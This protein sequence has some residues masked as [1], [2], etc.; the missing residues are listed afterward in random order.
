V[1]P[2]G[3]ASVT[4]F[5]D[6]TANRT[7]QSGQIQWKGSL[8]YDPLTNIILH[9]PTW[10]AEEG[11][12]P[13]LYDDGPIADGGHE[14]PGATADDYI[15]SVEVYVK[16]DDA[17]ETKF[18]YGVINEWGNWIWEGENGEFVLPA[19]STDLI[20]AEGYYI[21][22]F[23]TYDLIVTLDI[24]ELNPDFLPF[25]PAADKVYLKGSMNSWDPRQLLDNG[26]KGDQAAADGVYTYHHAENLGDHDG[27]LFAGQHV[28]FVF[29]LNQLEYKRIDALSDGVSARTNCAGPDIWEDVPIF[30]EPESRGRIKNTTVAICEGGGSVSV[31]SIVPSSGDP[32]GGTPVA[33]YGSAFADGAQVTFGG[34][35]AGDVVFVDPG[36]INCT[37]PAHDPGSVAVRVTNPGG[38]FGEL[39]DG[40]TYVQGDQ[41]EILFLQPG[42]GSTGGGTLVT[43]TGRRFM[44]G[45]QVTFGSD[46]AVEVSVNNAQEITCRTPAHTAGQ[47][48]VTV[49]NPGGLS[50]TFPEGFE[51][52]VSTGPHIQRVEPAVGSTAGGEDVTLI[53]SGFAAGA[54]AYFDDVLAQD[55]VVSPPGAIA[56]KTPPHAV[57]PV[58]VK[59]VNPNT[60]EDVLT[61]GFHYEEPQVDWAVLKWPL[62]M[63]LNASETSPLVFGQAFEP[64]LTE[65]AGCAAAMTAQLG[66]GPPGSDPVVD[67]GNWT[68]TDAACNDQ[69]TDCG[70]NDEFQASF[71]ISSGGQYDYTYR[72]SLDAGQTWVVADSGGTQDGY[73]PA[74]AGQ[75]TVRGGGTDL[76]I[77]G[78]TPPAGTVLG[79]TLITVAGNAFV[80]GAVVSLDGDVLSTTFVDANTL[81]AT[82]LSHAAGA[83]EVQVT[84]P[85]T[86]FVALPTGYHYV[87]RGT[88]V[89]DGEIDTNTGNDWDDAFLA[90]QNNAGGTWNPNHMDSL[91]VC[92]DDTNLYLGLSG[93]VEPGIGNAI[94]VYID[95]DYGPGTGV[96]NMNLLTDTSAGIDDAISSKCN[97]TAGGFGAEFAV[98]TQGMAGVEAADLVAEAGL[99]LLVS[100]AAPD[101]FG[102]LASTVKTSPT[103]HGVEAAITLET[104]L[105]GLP[106]EGARLAVFARLL[107]G[108]GQFLSNDTLPM[109]N[110][111]SP[112]EVGSVFVFDL[113]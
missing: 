33:V 30:M 54:V 52:V 42:S 3:Y 49:T 46:A 112:E 28:Q 111:A 21:H 39:S 22:A 87:L 69:C 92:F 80:D 106:V 88:P 103:E 12:Y 100:P 45:A 107:N 27:M 18:Q 13:V 70:N 93:W 75:V 61:N 8:I 63:L 14:R 2:E 37:T 86:E 110:P 11:P 57:G 78:V 113:R 108:D 64:G 71:Q 99:R 77:W 43:I 44:N 96:A 72:F 10:A 82:T 85:D 23:G 50:A 83:V 41:P 74:E 32:A 97:V 105:G 19:G 81:Q 47:V 25:D 73:S 53:G 9:D 109:D 79:G 62:S 4:F 26:E 6:D 59:V 95:V 29:M 24:A 1:K 15:F 84:N 17:F 67:P 35:S 51:Y 68:W 60:Q 91:Y 40:F 48:D 56:C 94:V 65:G 98:A 90:G 34:E 20:E 66:Y 76:E 36:Q 16:A 58:D 101:D 31:T 5:V 55:L 7:Y 102:W 38:V 89:L 104:L